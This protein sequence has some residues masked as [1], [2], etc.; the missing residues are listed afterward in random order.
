MKKKAEMEKSAAYVLYVSYSSVFNLLLSI[1]FKALTVLSR[2]PSG[3]KV[4]AE[5]AEASLWSLSVF[6][7]HF[8]RIGI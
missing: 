8:K 3:C 6:I 7:P 5:L 2:L 1:L 4:L